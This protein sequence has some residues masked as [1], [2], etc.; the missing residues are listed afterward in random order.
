M[1]RG[2]RKV[3]LEPVVGIEPMTYGLRIRSS[4]KTMQELAENQG[5]PVSGFAQTR[6]VIKSGCCAVLR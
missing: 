2:R 3:K 6:T 4:F 5:S 1:P